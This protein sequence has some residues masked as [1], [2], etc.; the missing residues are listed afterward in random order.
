MC[1]CYPA[2]LVI[3]ILIFTISADQLRNRLEE[4]RK[5]KDEEQVFVPDAIAADIQKA[6]KMANDNSKLILLQKKIDKYFCWYTNFFCMCECVWFTSKKAFLKH[7][8]L[9][10]K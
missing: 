9:S 2:W 3:F 7:D 6:V 4:R 10:A 1:D 5:S 8:V